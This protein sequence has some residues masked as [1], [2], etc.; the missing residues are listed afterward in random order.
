MRAVGEVAARRGLVSYTDAFGAT[1]RYDAL[2]QRYTMDGQL[3]SHEAAL[4]ELV[5]VG[6]RT[7]MFAGGTSIESLRR[8]GMVEMVG[9]G[10]GLMKHT[11][12]NDYDPR[13]PFFSL[14]WHVDDKVPFPTYARRAQFYLEHDWYLAA[15][16]QL[17]VYKRQPAIGGEHP[18]ALTGGHPRHSIHTVHLA[19]PLLMRLHRGQP[20]L[21]M[22]D[23]EAASRGIDNGEVVEVFNDV[24]D[25]EVMVRTSPTV[26][27]G[28]LVVYMWE[29]HQFRDWKIYDRLLVGQA[30]PL[31][32]A[33]GYGQLRF[34]MFNGS[35][36]PTADRGVRVD[37]RKRSAQRA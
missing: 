16:E 15:G 32:L 30:K 34:Y 8:D 29:G 5:E 3:A 31:H 9:H 14:R 27:P 6:V 26:A 36:G 17:P 11:V 28:Q 25:F 22:N 19:Q 20:V 37:V 33:G 23:E 2:W 13:K 1:R 10:E 35:P 12:A 24:G 21:H 7:R 18:F 4:A